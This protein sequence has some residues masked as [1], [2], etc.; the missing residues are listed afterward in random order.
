MP[1]FP[2]R[3][4]NA[5]D[6]ELRALCEVVRGALGELD[7]VRRRQ[8]ELSDMEAALAVAIDVRRRRI[9][10]LLDERSEVAVAAQ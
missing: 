5:I 2:R 1:A 8:S 3:R 9:D 4:L 7:E 6:S 10:E